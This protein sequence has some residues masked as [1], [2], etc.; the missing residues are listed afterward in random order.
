MNPLARITATHIA[1]TFCALAFL[2]AA[3]THA[4]PAAEELRALLGDKELR[5]STTG[6]SASDTF[7]A[8]LSAKDTPFVFLFESNGDRQALLMLDEKS[9][10]PVI[11]STNGYT[12]SFSLKHPGRLDLITGVHPEL[13][14]TRNSTTFSPLATGRNAYENAPFDL[15]F[16]AEAI[17]AAIKQ[18][19][20]IT[21]SV[22]A[23]N[24]PVF[25]VY[26]DPEKRIRL[27]IDPNAAY[28]IT[29]AAL[30][31]LGSDSI[32]FSNI[33]IN[34]PGDH[35]LTD[36]TRD[37]LQ[38]ANL[39]YA[40]QH[41]VDIVTRLSS[42]A[43]TNDQQSR[44]FMK[45]AESMLATYNQNMIP[46][47]TP[48]RLDSANA[49]LNLIN[50]ENPPAFTG[51]FIPPE[52]DWPDSSKHHKLTFSDQTTAAAFPEDSS[53]VTV[54]FET[55]SGIPFVSV[56]INDR[57]VGRFLVD[58]GAEFT[59]V[60]IDLANQ[61]GL[62]WKKSL[63]NVLQEAGGT[64][65]L[66]WRQINSIKIGDLT[67]PLEKIAAADFSAIR[68]TV[69]DVAGVIGS[70]ILERVPFTVDYQNK[71][72]A[73]HNPDAFEPDESTRPLAL[74]IADGR[75]H[76]P[77]QLLDTTP[78]SCLIDTGMEGALS[79]NS[80]F[81]NN[82]T[83]L[84][85]PLRTWR[86]QAV[87]ASHELVRTRKRLP[88]NSV[89]IF[90]TTIDAPLG[91]D[92]IDD[93]SHDGAIGAVILSRFRLTYDYQNKTLH[94][95]DVPNHP[96]PAPDQINTPDLR[97]RTPLELAAAEGNLGRIDALI[98]AGADPN[99]DSSLAHAVNSGS[100]EIVALLL[101]QGANPNSRPTVP[102][103]AAAKSGQTDLVKV[104]LEAG[105]DPAL[106]HG[107]AVYNA[108][109]H[110]ETE[111]VRLLLDAGGPLKVGSGTPA[112][113]IAIAVEQ[114]DLETT[115][116]LLDRELDPNTRF[117]DGTTLLW[118]AVINK[119][120][121]VA[122]LLLD[123]GA[124]PTFRSSD[125]R[126][127]LHLAAIAN[128]NKTLQHALDIDPTIINAADANGF[129]PLHYAAQLNHADALQ[130]LLN[131]GADPGIPI[132]NTRASA[133]HLAAE[134][135]NLDAARILLES[136]QPV[137]VDATSDTGATP[138]HV[139]AR[140]GRNELVALLLKH[141]ADP[142]KK[143]LE[144]NTPLVIAANVNA[145]R[146]LAQAGDDE[147]AQSIGFLDQLADQNFDHPGAIADLVE[148]G[149]DLDAVHPKGT[150]LVDFLA[151]DWRL[152][153]L[154]LKLLEQ[155][156]DFQ[157]GT[158]LFY[159]AS[160][161]NT[162]IITALL[163]RGADPNVP[164]QLP[165]ILVAAFTGRPQTV[166][167]L[168]KH[169]ADPNTTHAGGETALHVA[170]AHNDPYLIEILINAGI[171]PNVTDQNGNTPLHHAVENTR[172]TS[173]HSLLKN[174]AN[175]DS[176]NAVA[177]SPRTLA[178]YATNQKAALTSLFDRFPPK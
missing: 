56:A 68:E 57:E 50:P 97:N 98:K 107:F 22:D 83:S 177:M 116:L 89:T 87:G 37:Q 147:L 125:E 28:P 120:P 76:T 40:I 73:F 159:A 145:V 106:N 131:H 113:I 111:I 24:S 11:Y 77:V 124:D 72:I 173:I 64:Q 156:L 160:L 6:P 67:F 69:A 140:S 99:K 88:P 152:N 13:K 154:T 75:P 39:N 122:A 142:N 157:S 62:P 141:N 170:V 66:V 19:T 118:G 104:L 4:S 65:E 148:A 70:D 93:A 174:G 126:S 176:K 63:G 47:A 10:L 112:N 36:F 101:D 48:P 49:F 33:S 30:E 53:S 137:N 32:T 123:R 166:E 105:A 134:N 82:H 130:L 102:L 151:A 71:T 74:N 164:D 128:D 51:E 121:D 2:G 25:S 108:V 109:L 15:S 17:N 117:T 169:G 132:T 43:S 3:P 127:L 167:A 110:H 46:P 41:A 45:A 150:R 153:P 34:A 60:R 165:P 175:P 79:V 135:N 90:D 144:G 38:E 119:Q 163:E 96:V 114:G 12:L 80:S 52:E 172:L 84:T 9:G 29:G 59:V 55:A 7:S 146:L 129:T 143:D 95:A 85:D 100:P 91:L 31:R 178:S 103:A 158:P 44:D 42:P 138:L 149:A 58:T 35:P 61:L 26:I 81:A 1:A 54:P 86:S 168:L 8:T 171:D 27:K 16:I 155:N 20:L 14:V 162:E 92:L 161:G 115:R 133:L 23:E 94:V 78:V 136:D 5:L 21:K 18:N 139:A